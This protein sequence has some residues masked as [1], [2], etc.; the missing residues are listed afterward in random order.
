MDIVTD[1]PTGQFGAL[2]NPYQIGAGIEKYPHSGSCVD[3]WCMR[4]KP[5]RVA[6]AGGMTSNVEYVLHRKV[7]TRQL[8]RRGTFDFDRLVV[9]EGV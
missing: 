2:R 8:P 1:D 5:I 9:A 6:R 7:I 4:V 3:R